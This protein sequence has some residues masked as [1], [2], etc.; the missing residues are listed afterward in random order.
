MRLIVTRE[1]PIVSVKQWNAGRMVRMV[2]GPGFHVPVGGWTQ[3]HFINNGKALVKTLQRVAT[4]VKN[5]VGASIAKKT[6]DHIR[7][8][9]DRVLERTGKALD[10]TG[11]WAEAM[12]EVLGSM[13]RKYRKAIEADV[14][15]LLG[16]GYSKTNVIL[17]RKD[18]PKG[19]HRRLDK[20]EK[21]LDDM[22]TIDDTT[23]AEMHALS[24]RLQ[25]EGYEADEMRDMFR[26]TMYRRSTV[27][28][29][30]A[31]RTVGQRAWSGGSLDAMNESGRVLTVDVIGCTSREYDQWGK[32][33]FQDYMFDAD[34]RPPEGT[35]NI[36]N[37]PIEFADLL[38]WHPNHT[39]T[40]VPSEFA[41]PDEEEDDY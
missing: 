38:E 13:K 20:A 26:K 24:K 30:T 28:G 15:S 6:R 16:Q 8:E 31:G 32:P 25:E 37:V 40:V 35:C 9:V 1:R 5:R 17:G 12:G 11:L 2:G 10:L 4:L 41:D 29:L 21:V 34:G 3:P 27:R 18:D 33:S 36:K 39:G 23:A 14:R 7:M 19:A 22:D